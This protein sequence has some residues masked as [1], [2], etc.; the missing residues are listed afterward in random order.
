[1]RQRRARRI[2]ARP[3]HGWVTLVAVVTLAAGCSS[4]EQP[5]PGSPTGTGAG[6][7]P[8]A[9]GTLA[10][11]KYART[12]PLGLPRYAG[13]KTTYLSGVWVGGRPNVPAW[14]GFGQWRKAPVDVVL[15]YNANTTWEAMKNDG[16]IALFAE[17]PGTLVYG[18]GLVPSSGGS[19]REVREGK[20]DDV[21]R[22]TAAG[23]IKHGRQRSVVRLGL[24]ANGTWFPWGAKAETA[25]DFKAAFRHVAEI[26]RQEG[27]EP[28]I[29]FDIG[30]GVGLTGD[31][32][33]QA[34]LQRL[35][36]GNDVV[37]LIGCDIYDDKHGGVGNPMAQGR[38]SRGPSLNDVLDFAK[39]HGK[40]MVVPEWGLDRNYGA[41]DNPDFIK[42]M[43][44]FFDQNA[45]HIALEIYFN[46][47][48][49]DIKSSLWEP[50]QNPR[51]AAEYE[52]IW[53]ERGVPR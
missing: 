31:S 17:F 8:S 48:G 23:L 18:V 52:R 27:A 24:E 30:C 33:P 44:G 42:G 16:N 12:G 38:A 35:Y 22:A 7:G 50:N 40:K 1:M 39:N 36:P 29:T 43:Y 46:E 2:V 9:P 5:P 13:S 26:L 32:D 19:L 45:D 4:A 47:G 14:S 11:S 21:W 3:L 15:G 49:S 51:A 20:H 6:A 37:D 34:P 28:L 25:E 53:S 41:G 10:S